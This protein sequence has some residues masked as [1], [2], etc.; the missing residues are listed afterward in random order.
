MSKLSIRLCCN[1]GPFC[2]EELDLESLSYINKIGRGLVFKGNSLGSW[3]DA[4]WSGSSVSPALGCVVIRVTYLT[5]VSQTPSLLCSDCR[6]M[7]SW[8]S[9][10]M[11]SNTYE[12]RG[13]KLMYSSVSEQKGSYWLLG[14]KAE[15]IHFTLINLPLKFALQSKLR[16]LWIY[17]TWN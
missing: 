1:Y 16:L 12:E 3:S 11:T 5:T 10:V 17:S 15:V 7:F 13:K 2:R 9:Q 6:A 8:Y 4:L 14:H